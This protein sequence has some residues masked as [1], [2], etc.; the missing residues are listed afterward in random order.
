MD[1]VW[2]L[3]RRHKLAVI[4]DAAHACGTEYKGQRVGGLSGTDMTVFGFMR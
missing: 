1:D 3:A 2:A 4:E